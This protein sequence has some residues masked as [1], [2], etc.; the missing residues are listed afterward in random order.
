MEM[1]KGACEKRLLTNIVLFLLPNANLPSKRLEEQVP[2]SVRPR[3]FGLL[4]QNKG[5]EFAL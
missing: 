3:F 2:L 4:L 5:R 1:G